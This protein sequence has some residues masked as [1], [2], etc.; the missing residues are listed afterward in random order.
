MGCGAAKQKARPQI[1]VLS[2]RT[3]DKGRYTV[4]Q[5]K[6]RLDLSEQRLTE[7]PCYAGTGAVEKLDLSFNDLQSL[8]QNMTEGGEWAGLTDLNLSNNSLPRVPLSVAKLP[9]LHTL[10][11][12]GNRLSRPL[13]ESLSVVQQCPSLTSLYLSDCGLDIVPQALAGSSTLKELSVGRNHSID[14]EGVVKL[15]GLTSLDVSDCMISRLP[16]CLAACKELKVLDVSENPVSDL[17]SL[18]LLS[19]LSTLKLRRLPI[20]QQLTESRWLALAKAPALKSLDLSQNL[21]LSL[22]GIYMVTNLTALDLSSCSLKDLPE[23][24]HDCV[25]LQ[26]LNLQNNLFS[27]LD[28]LSTGNLK[29]TLQSL[30]VAGN[31]FAMPPLR[32]DDTAWTEIGQLAELR[33]LVF[34]QWADRANSRNS[35]PYST[36]MPWS[37]LRVPLGYL[38]GIT[39]RTPFTKDPGYN[40]ANLLR[41]G[42][43][44]VDMGIE[45][46]VRFGYHIK[47]LH[48]F[49]HSREW[50]TFDWRASLQRYKMF[51]Y[52]Q[53]RLAD[54]KLIAPLDVAFIHYIH[55]TYPINYRRDCL[56]MFGVVVGNYYHGVDRTNPHIRSHK[57]FLSSMRF[58]EQA[59]AGKPWLSFD[60]P[61]DRLPGTGPW[62]GSVEDWPGATQ[63]LNDASFSVDFPQVVGEIFDHIEKITSFGDFLEQHALVAIARYMRF[64]AIEG[65]RYATLST[66][67][68]PA[69]I[70]TEG[71]PSQP[72]LSEGATPSSQS[73]DPAPTHPPSDDC[74]ELSPELEELEK[75][76][77]SWSNLAATPGIQVMLHVHQCMPTKLYSDFMVLLGG[78]FADLNLRVKGKDD[79]LFDAAMGETKR[80]WRETWGEDFLSEGL[81][82]DS[83]PSFF[84]PT[85]QGHMRVLKQRMTFAE[86][87]REE[88]AAQGNVPRRPSLRQGGDRRNTGGAKQSPGVKFIQSTGL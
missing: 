14:L 36:R 37:L 68:L 21:F 20:D 8:P 53:H 86:A 40:L 58:W 19:A 44:K 83:T 49:H 30:N 67:V 80:L 75:T 46:E 3:D 50:L 26:D 64:L 24:L 15:Q 28:G 7:L 22:Q 57:R 73:L 4:P 77:P 13:T 39:L 27:T 70:T 48:L 43:F 29:T 65:M 85:A 87:L 71:T 61:R 5:G 35:N 23:A 45:W 78:R 60:Y 9:V 74:K 66:F 56:N 41:E 17:R 69:D 54:E 33:S 88:Q 63:E 84:S 52:L 31:P 18:E 76:P 25:Q 82:K 10:R 47:M 1:T 16:T 34:Q 2:G 42:Y 62:E 11:L 72:V 81:L 12:N 51:L 6:T 79:P 38:N 59:Y 55:M 32:A